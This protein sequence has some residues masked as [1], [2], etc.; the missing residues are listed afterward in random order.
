MLNSKNDEK[1]AIELASKLGEGASETQI[2][3]MEVKLPEMKRGPIAKI[4]DKVI[5]IYNGFRSEETPSSLKV[6][7]I[8]SLL[9][10]VLPIDVIPDFIPVGG[11][12]DDAAVLSYVWTKL[13]KL[14]K[15]GS[16]LA[17]PVVKQTVGDKVQESIKNGYNKA[18]EFAKNKLDEILKKKAKT[19]VKNCISNLLVFVVAILF[20][21]SGSKEGA[22]IASI[23]IIILFV[24]SLI[25][26]I[27]ASKIGFRLLRIYIK[28]KDIDETISVYMKETY[29]F[30][31]PIEEMKNKLKILSDI[32]DLK[33][34]VKLQ[35]KSLRKTI[36]EVSIT[37]ILAIVLAFVFK[38]VLIF[39]TD[40]KFIEILALPFT[41]LINIF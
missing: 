40:Y 14:A 41:R 32:P 37:I 33:E 27:K 18:F 13:S 10:L 24:R 34:L 6:L 35:R 30:I 16:H 7:L 19:I 28:E 20:L 5:D 8:G 36:I 22:L 11:L 2:S 25:S 4:W 26:L 15:L 17:S 39:N 12:V 1:K 3:N 29:T 9:Y 31:S 23:L 21:S 38:R